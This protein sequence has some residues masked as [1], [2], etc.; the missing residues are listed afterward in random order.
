MI[1]PGCL[2]GIEADWVQD[3]RLLIDRGWNIHGAR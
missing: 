3:G 1:Y 2:G